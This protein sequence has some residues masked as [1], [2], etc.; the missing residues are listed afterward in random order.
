MFF[1]PKKEVSE[2]AYSP[3]HRYIAQSEVEVTHI[4]PHLHFYYSKHGVILS[5]QLRHLKHDI[6]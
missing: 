4:Y 5:L 2:G 3:T 1:Y 6:P